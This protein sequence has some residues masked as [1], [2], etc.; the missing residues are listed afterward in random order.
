MRLSFV[1]FLEDAAPTVE[2]LAFEQNLEI[3]ILVRR[4]PHF[5]RI[6]ILAFTRAFQGSWTGIPFASR[7]TAHRRSMTTHGFIICIFP[8]VADSFANDRD[9]FRDVHDRVQGFVRAR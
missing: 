4:L 8:Y 2:C 9:R 5:A 6:P 7:R 1:S 3:D